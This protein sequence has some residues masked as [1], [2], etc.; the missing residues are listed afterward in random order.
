VLRGGVVGT[1]RGWFPYWKGRAVRVRR[2]L[3]VIESG[4]HLFRVARGNV[5]AIKERE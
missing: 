5:I 3:V 4:G 2:A 1:V